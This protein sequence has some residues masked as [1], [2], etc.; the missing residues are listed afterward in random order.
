MRGVLTSVLIFAIACQASRNESQTEASS[1]SHPESDIFVER[2]NEALRSLQ[3]GL[4]EALTSAMNEGGASSA[5]HVCREEA[6][7]ITTQVAGDEGI[8][9]GRTSHRLRNPSN[10][11]RPWA[12]DLVEQA[13]G[14]KTSDVEMHVI[15]LV[16]RIGVLKPIN[17]L[18]LCTNCHG[19]DIDTDV[20]KALSD[21]YP[22]DLAVDFE[23]GD[24]RGWMWAE[25]PNES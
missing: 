5:V 7:A 8:L 19:N 15:D 14:K 13:A 3:S 20:R 25:V 16:D 21:A 4:I 10:A 22:E 2:A 23:T 24:L 12:R 6:Q 17:T 18:D 11:P 1:E 9:V